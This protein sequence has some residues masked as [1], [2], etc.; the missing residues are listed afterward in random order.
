MNA[1]VAI[2]IRSAVEIQYTQAESQRAPRKKMSP[3]RGVNKSE[4]ECRIYAAIQSED[5]DL[6][7]RLFDMSID[8]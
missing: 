3:R 6:A 7:F 8:V 5:E 1:I 4:R 2:A